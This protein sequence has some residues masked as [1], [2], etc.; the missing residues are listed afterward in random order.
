M[1]A[2]N[3]GEISMCSPGRLPRVCLNKVFIGDDAAEYYQFIKYKSI[4]FDVSTVRFRRVFNEPL[5][6]QGRMNIPRQRSNSTKTY[7]TVL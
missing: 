6:H 1:N 2:D 3:P 7:R 4:V 5:N